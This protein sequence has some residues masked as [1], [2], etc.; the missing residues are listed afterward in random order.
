MG[1]MKQVQYW[2]YTILEQPVNLSVIW[3]FMLSKC[4][5]INT[6][7]YVQKLIMLNIL[8][9]I[10]KRLVTYMTMCL[11]HT[12]VTFHERSEPCAKPPKTFDECT[13]PCAKLYMLL[14]NTISFCPSDVVIYCKILQSDWTVPYRYIVNVNNKMWEVYNNQTEKK[15]NVY[16]CGAFV[17][18]L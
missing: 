8:G 1:D 16:I 10:L 17:V 15:Q 4:E 2:Q 6:F 3:C 9:T 11:R 18:E 13:E 7:M 14:H 5:L 12:V